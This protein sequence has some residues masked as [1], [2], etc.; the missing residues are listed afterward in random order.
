MDRSES[1]QEYKQAWQWHIDQLASLALAGDI[2][3]EAFIS[4]K[5]ELETWLKYA[6]QRQ[7]NK[8]VQNGKV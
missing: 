6:T 7:L 8:G 3:Y 2:D 5:R 1:A 4:V